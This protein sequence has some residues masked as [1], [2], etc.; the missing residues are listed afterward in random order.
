MGE[1]NKALLT[2]AS[3]AQR[4]QEDVLIAAARQGDG[5]HG[6][7]LASRQAGRLHQLGKA[8]VESVGKPLNAFAGKACVYDARKER[9]GGK[10]ERV[11]LDAQALVRL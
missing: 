7:A 2:Q 6:R 10:D 1:H 9:V 11:V 5:A 4:K 8:E 3:G